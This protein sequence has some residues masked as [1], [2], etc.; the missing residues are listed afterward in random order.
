MKL[1]WWTL[2]VILPVLL[3]VGIACGDDATPTT[4]AQPTVAAPPTATTVPATPVP[5]ATLRPGETPKPT[6]TARPAATRA[7]APTVA[8]GKQLVDPR[9]KVSITIPV[10]QHVVF[11]KNFATSQIVRQIYDHMIW[12]DRYDFSPKPM[13]AS[14]WS[15]S[16]DGLNWTFK[17]VKGAPFH[18]APGFP[19]DEFTAKDVIRSFEL[20]EAPGARPHNVPAMREKVAVSSNIEVI[21]NH[22]IVFRLLS[23]WATLDT[24]IWENRGDVL[25]IYSAK[26]WDE[27]GQEVYEKHPVGTGPFKFVEIKINESILYERFKEVG[28]DHWWQIPAFD[29]FQI[30]FVPEAATRL[31]Q[32]VAEETHIAEL[33]VLLVEEAKRQGMEV[34][35]STL[36]GAFL[37]GL[38]S[39]QNHRAISDDPRVR[40]DAIL[41]G[42][43]K[44]HGVE[45]LYYP[46]D[47]LV[48]LKGRQAVNHAI[49]RQLLKDTYFGDTVT[50][51]SIH[52]LY[53]FQG[54]WKDEWIPYEYKPDLARQLLDEA[55]FPPGSINLTVFV[56]DQW[57][58]FNEAADVAESMAAMWN[59]VG[60]N[61]TLDTRETNEVYLR[62]RKA[63]ITRNTIYISQFAVA[64]TELQWNAGIRGPGSSI[65]YD[66]VLDALLVD[67][68]GPALDRQVREDL[69]LQYGQRMYDQYATLPLFATFPRAGMNQGVIAEYEANYGGVGPVRHHE[70]TIPVYK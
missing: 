9:L 22:T 27:F 64:R 34:N 19:G 30:F 23:P 53:P 48:Q 4:A 63:S 5:T 57:P 43:R 40:A 70:F 24:A 15:M 52:G 6:A 8:P 59:E 68:Y 38:F 32:L 54:P 33:P 2:M 3:L 29:E 14:E 28:E 55:G 51:D 46:D 25:P 16:P 11:Y 50:F 36:P 65:F 69:E 17:L 49:D 62:M 12:T 56:S 58:A 66:D 35:T 13:L 7:P 39:G 47:L 20:A 18:D 44:P 67:E 61:T 1:Q 60:I 42:H 21:D 31:A 10:D 37:W 45:P 26:Y 41:D